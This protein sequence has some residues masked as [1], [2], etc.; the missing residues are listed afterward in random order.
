MNYVKN[1]KVSLSQKAGSFKNIQEDKI[2]KVIVITKDEGVYIVAKV[3]SFNPDDVS[4]DPHDHV[5]ISRKGEFNG[6]PYILYSRSISINYNS[7]NY[8]DNIITRLRPD[9]LDQA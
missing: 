1:A 7:Y 5:K 4:V 3:L 2:S 6:R 9:E 8:I